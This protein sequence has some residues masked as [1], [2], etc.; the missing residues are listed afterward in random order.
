MALNSV[1]KPYP[2]DLIT[3]DGPSGVLEDFPEAL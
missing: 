3:F 2:R 1:T